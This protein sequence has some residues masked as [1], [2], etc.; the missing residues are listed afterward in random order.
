MESTSMYAAEAAMQDSDINGFNR[1]KYIDSG[2]LIITTI[3]S[4]RKILNRN[5]RS[6][7]KIYLLG[8]N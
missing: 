7:S 6:L 4:T 5:W 3:T 2:T 1:M 8:S